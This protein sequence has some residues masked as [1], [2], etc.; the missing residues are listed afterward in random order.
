MTVAEIV[1]CCKTVKDHNKP[2]KDCP[3]VI[4]CKNF[5]KDLRKAEPLEVEAVIKKNY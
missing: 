5:L 2:C 4:E 1:C 3:C